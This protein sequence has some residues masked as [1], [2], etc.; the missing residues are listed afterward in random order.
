M[1]WAQLLQKTRR[2]ASVPTQHKMPE[3]SE[4]YRLREVRQTRRYFRFG[5]A[6]I[7]C[8]T[9]HPQCRLCRAL[10]LI[11]GLTPDQPFFRQ[12][13][14]PTPPPLLRE[15]LTCTGS[16]M[17]D[18]YLDQNPPDHNEILRC[19]QTR[20]NHAWDRWP[21]PHIATRGQPG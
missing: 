12:T 21:R 15:M 20:A 10:P 1:I 17:T 5:R 13:P 3:S 4:A 14:P 18:R 16:T 9:K 8:R 19:T 11:D 7:S 2:Q 6:S